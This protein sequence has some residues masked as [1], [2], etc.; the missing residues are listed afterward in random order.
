M[1]AADDL[2]TNLLCSVRLKLHRQ[3]NTFVNMDWPPRLPK[4]QR[5]NKRR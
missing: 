3:T 2:Y 1:G 5:S 4:T